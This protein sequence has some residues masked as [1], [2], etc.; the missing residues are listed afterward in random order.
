MDKI[1][2][3]SFHKMIEDGFTEKMIHHFT[4]YIN[5]EKEDAFAPGF[6]KWAHEHGFR[7][8]NASSLS[9][10]EDN[11]KDYISDYEFYKTFPHNSWLRLW[12]ND[13]LTLKYML[14]GTDW[15]KYM[16][17]YYYYSTNA[18]IRSLC[19][20][21]YQ[22]NTFDSFLKL[23]REKGAFACK[24]N[25]GTECVGFHKML[26]NT[27]EDKFYMDGKCVEE[28]ELKS[29]VENTPNYIY[30]E[31]LLPGYGLEKIY[32]KIHTLRVTV[33][34]E[35]SK[36]PIIIGGYLRFPTSQSGEANFTSSGANLMCKVNMKTGEIVEPTLIF[37]RNKEILS[38]HPDT[39]CPFEKGMRIP[40]WNEVVDMAKGVS[41]FFFGCQFIGFDLG[42]TN[43]GVKIMEIN[44]LPGNRGNQWSRDV[45]DKNIYFDFIKRRIAEIDA[46]SPEERMQRRYIK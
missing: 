16:P 17:E 46:M 7:A 38:E 10:N 29:F 28:K 21:P 40:L 36:N 34:N 39:H 22:D 2:D 6:M 13:K 4:K 11:Y 12:V 9:I 32:N 18:G 27:S 37:K 25:N 31:Y 43:K 45:N 26:Y 35:D 1:V 44:T 30:T 23:L 42:I 14:N 33:I 15:G 3:Y 20:N 41:N 5:A 19:D 8:S 24:P